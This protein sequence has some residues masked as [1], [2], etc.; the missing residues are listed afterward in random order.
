MAQDYQPADVD[1][2]GMWHDWER[3]EES[4]ASSD[5]L[6]KAPDLQAYTVSVVER[7]IDRPATD[8]RIY[9]VRN[10]FFN[11]SM[12]PTG[13][14]VVHTGFMARVH[15]EA[16]YAAVLGHEAGH[17]F[18]KHNLEGYRDRRTKLAVGAFVSAG[19]GA[20]AGYSATQGID[21]RSWID[22]ANSIN[23]ALVASIF[24]F[25]RA[26]ETE[27]DAY[28]IGLMARA[29]YTPHAASDVWRQVI[30]ERKASARERDRRY[31]ASALHSYST[32]PP[33]EERMESLA[34]TAAILRPPP[35]RS[36]DV[37]A[38]SW[39]TTI[40][41][42]R[43]LL[44]DEQVKLNDPGASLYL[45]E[46]LAQDGWTGLLRY[47]QGEVYR[48]RNADGDNSLA[49]GAYASSVTQSDAPAEAWRAHGYVLLKSGRR[50]EGRIA[51]T[52]YLELKPDA[53]DAAM[54]RFTL[55]Q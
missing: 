37:G 13:V 33:T 1:E 18:R 54:V 31:K 40:A 43:A 44:L 47:Y 20:V 27:A 29:G 26:Q 39:K 16:Q 45:I 28:G 30:E 52:R 36:F 23:E 24:R 14:M 10:A 22:L 8:L 19:A 46:S 6:L 15:N 5:T 41:P 49:A 50:D 42:Y 11:A 9:L 2:R 55:E 38:E 51:L 17:F 32:H 4:L 21:G 3:L 34:E 25:S 12:G 7:L 35:D 48:L 53:K